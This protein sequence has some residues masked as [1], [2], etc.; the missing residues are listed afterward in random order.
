MWQIFLIRAIC[1]LEWVIPFLRSHSCCFSAS[2][3]WRTLLHQWAESK[4]CLE[5]SRVLHFNTQTTSKSCFH[6]PWRVCWF[7]FNVPH[8][9]TLSCIYPAPRSTSTS[10]RWNSLSPFLLYYKGKLTNTMLGA[11]RKSTKWV[12]PGNF[13][14]FW[15]HVQS[16]ITVVTS[17]F[18]SQW[19]QSQVTT[20]G[21]IPWTQD[22]KEILIPFFPSSFISPRK[23]F[24][25]FNLRIDLT[26]I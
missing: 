14:W 18:H 6:F 3:P 17:D 10:S 12:E 22:L 7:F 4:S 2:L 19:E 1:F 23:R 11:P 26:R 21:R 20:L 9:S 15:G 13:M 25:P 8:F 5:K 24:K 16:N